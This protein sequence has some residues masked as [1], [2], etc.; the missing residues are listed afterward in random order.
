MRK[1]FLNV[2]SGVFFTEIVRSV[3]GLTGQEVGRSLKVVNYEISDWSIQ[4]TK[5][6]SDPKGSRE[7]QKWK[8]IATHC[9]TEERSA[10]KWLRLI[11]KNVSVS[12]QDV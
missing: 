11:I 8:F 10:R 4:K 3:L 6:P 12:K 1:P 5:L 2:F 7:R 9:K